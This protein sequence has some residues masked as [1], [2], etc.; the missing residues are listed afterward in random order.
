[1]P[2]R[3]PARRALLAPISGAHDP[4]PAMNTTPLIDVLLVLLVM[5]IITIPVQTHKLPVDLPAGPSTGA[6]PVTHR[7]AIA[8][9]GAYSWDGTPL[10]DAALP[11]RLRA[12]VADPDGAI[13]IV[14]ADGE[15]RYDRF[16]RTMAIIKRAGVTK[17]GFAGN[18]R[19]R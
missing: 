13:L 10:A 4:E 11:E 3:N 5:L 14:A 7:L 1:M 2:V 9:G 6:P 18:E 12:L 16:D 17:L 19:W 15:T 8:A